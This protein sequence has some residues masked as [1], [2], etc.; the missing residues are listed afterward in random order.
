VAVACFLISFFSVRERVR[1]SVHQKT[2]IKKDLKDLVTNKPWLILFFVSLTTLVYIAIRSS[3]IAYYFKYY[4]DRESQ[5]GIFMAVGTICVLLGVL[6]TKWLSEK[7]GKRKLYIASTAIVVL[8]SGLFFFVQPG[9]FVMA[10][11]I[12][13]IFSLASGPAMP[14]L[15]SMLSDAA[16]YSEWKNHRRATGL[17]FSA[18]TFSQKSG[19]ALGGII[20]MSM[21]SMFGF[22][23]NS[24]QTALSLQGIRLAMS[25]VPALMAL[26]GFGLLFFYP[27]TEAKVHEISMDLEERKKRD[28]SNL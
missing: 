12:H 19:F 4:M 14:L 9:N 7:I 8:S 25:V 15:W 16:D 17:A 11:V 24:E 27:L 28:Y 6:P 1:P 3:A 10:Y 22:V 18:L 13:I 21:L 20:V 23:A 2:N 26:V 5:M